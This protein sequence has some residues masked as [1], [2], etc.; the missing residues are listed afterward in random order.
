MSCFDSLVAWQLEN[1]LS[2]CGDGSEKKEVTHCIA[3][4]VM[5][6]QEVA[7]CMVQVRSCWSIGCL[8]QHMECK[9]R[10]T[11]KNFL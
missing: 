10:E 7:L 3:E 9:S 6:L 11:G 5:S 2:E 1:D 8:T 4:M